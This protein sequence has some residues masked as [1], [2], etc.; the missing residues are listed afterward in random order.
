M[1]PFANYRSQEVL[2]WEWFFIHIAQCNFSHL[3]PQKKLNQ[4]MEAFAKKYTWQNTHKAANA[5]LQVPTFSQVEQYKPVQA[6][7]A[8]FLQTLATKFSEEAGRHAAH[9]PALQHKRVPRER[10]HTANCWKI[11]HSLDL[12]TSAPTLKHHS[13]SRI[14]VCSCRLQKRDLL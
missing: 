13:L 8:F 11:W 4:T 2:T 5:H 9:S 3:H 10:T 1:G 12:V 6:V 14:D 7:Q